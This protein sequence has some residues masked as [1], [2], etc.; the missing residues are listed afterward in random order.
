MASF[1]VA[2]GGGAV[3]TWYSRHKV[4]RLPSAPAAIVGQEWRPAIVVEGR[5][6]SVQ[7]LPAK[8]SEQGRGFK[9]II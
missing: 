4:Q 8:R 7:E 9:Y 1:L 6:D 3:H 5:A 2:L